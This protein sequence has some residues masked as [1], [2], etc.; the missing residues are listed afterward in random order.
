METSLGSIFFLDSTLG[1]FFLLFLLSLFFLFYNEHNP[2]IVL[3][4]LELQLI[5]ICLI[6]VY[7]SL[8]WQSILGLIFSLFVVAFAGAEAS[9]GISVLIAQYRLRGLFSIEYPSSSEFY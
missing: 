7:L 9:V 5:L 8:T 3:V 1:T 2:F 6:A 4:P